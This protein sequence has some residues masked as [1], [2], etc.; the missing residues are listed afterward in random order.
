MRM[1][2]I[3]LFF[4]GYVTLS[5]II[6]KDFVMFAVIQT[7]GRQYKVQPGSKFSIEK[8]NVD[9]GA[10]LVFDQVVLFSADDKKTEIGEPFV[11]GV[12][13]TCLVKA[14]KRDEKII[15]FKKRRRKNSRRKT[16]HRQRITIVEVKS[17]DKK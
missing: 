2:L 6:Y 13:V 3:L 17:I 10:D 4:W 5:T 7:G 9:P 14:Q 12:S 11:E 1:K 16:G 15:I 8:V